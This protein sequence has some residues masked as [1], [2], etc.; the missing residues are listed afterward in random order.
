MKQSNGDLEEKTKVLASREAEFRATQDEMKETL[1]RERIRNSEMVIEQERLNNQISLLQADNEKQLAII[2]TMQSEVKY[3]K[4]INRGEVEEKLLFSKKLEESEVKMM[5]LDESRLSLELRIADKEKE[6]RQLKYSQSEF[7]Q[8]IEDVSRGQLRNQLM[9]NEIIDASSRLESMSIS[10]H[11]TDS[12]II[13]PEEDSEKLNRIK[14][15]LGLTEGR[16][17]KVL[18]LSAE[19]DEMLAR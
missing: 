15:L 5:G 3:L 7:E 17:R 8:R 12:H 19:K 18:E 2:A 6:I 14:K 11:S 9:L 1:R 16:F 13:Y 4:D 10:T